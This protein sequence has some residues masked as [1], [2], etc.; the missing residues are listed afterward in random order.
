M[1]W[2]EIY[3]HAG[4]YV[5]GRLVRSHVPNRDSIGASLSG[6]YEVLPGIREVS[7]S[8]FDAPPART[9]RTRTLAEDIRQS[10]EINPLIV[11]VDEQ[12]PYILE[13]GH[14]YDALRI[15]DAEAFPALV[16]IEEEAL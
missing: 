9:H 4:K 1:S 13:G 14:R 11:A 15:L 8:L 16:V 2:D 3:P 12:G 5:D 7:M 10:G 6:D